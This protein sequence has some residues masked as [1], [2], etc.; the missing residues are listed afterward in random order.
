MAHY[1][2]PKN[3]LIQVYRNDI[4][5]ELQKMEKKKKREIA[6]VN[7]GFYGYIDRTQ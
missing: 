1:C 5:K 3:A 6:Y 7:A 4:E 2:Y